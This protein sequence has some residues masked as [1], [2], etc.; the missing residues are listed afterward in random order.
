MS[1]QKYGDEIYIV[2]DQVTE[3]IASFNIG[4]V[5][6]YFFKEVLV[7]CRDLRDNTL[8]YMDPAT[9]GETTASFP[10]T[11]DGYNDSHVKEITA[12]KSPSNEKVTSK[13][14]SEFAP[15]AIRTCMKEFG[16]YMDRI[17][18]NETV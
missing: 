1:D 3:E 17:L 15:Y 16:F 6:L 10:P 13:H 11:I 9:K 5:S 12:D 18:V 14:V 8:V 2:N 7:A 4:E